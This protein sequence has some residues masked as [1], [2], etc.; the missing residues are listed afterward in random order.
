M[1]LLQT[2]VNKRADCDSFLNSKL[3]KDK[4]KEM[5]MKQ[6]L[7]LNEKNEREN[8]DN[9]GRLLNTIKFDN[10]K[11]LKQQLPSTKN[12]ENIV[13]NENKE[14]MNI[15]SNKIKIKNTMIKKIPI[16]K[17]KTSRNKLII[18]TEENF[19]MKIII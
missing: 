19:L 12:Y 6:K 3:I 2:D 16:I 4:I 14:N 15:N 17:N 18:K 9:S 7:H 1:M 11:D 10:I 5:D 8:N 13:L